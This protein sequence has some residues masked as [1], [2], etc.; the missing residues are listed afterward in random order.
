[1]GFDEPE[2]LVHLARD[3]SEEVNGDGV[4]EVIG[5]LDRGTQ[6]VGVMAD[7]VDEKFHH[8]GAV[9]GGEVGFRD[10]GLRDGFT[11]C[12]VGDATE[13]GDAFRDCVDV[14]FQVGGDGIEEQV[15]LV[16][17]LPFYIPV[18]PF[19]LAVRVDAVGQAEIQKGD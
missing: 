15:E 10:A 18:C 5:F 6:G 4:F 11:D 16:E 14:I 17:I 1:M 13:G 3:A 8:V 2:V 12:S 7:V 19:D 9:V